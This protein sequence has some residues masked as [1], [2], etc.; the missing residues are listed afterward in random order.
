MR[1]KEDKETLTKKDRFRRAILSPPVE[2]ES[3]EIRSLLVGWAESEIG[4]GGCME[5]RATKRGMTQE[6]LEIIVRRA[7]GSQLQPREI[8]NLTKA[9]GNKI[10][11]TVKNAW[12]LKCK[13]KWVTESRESTCRQKGLRDANETMK[14]MEK[15]GYA[16]RCKKRGECVNL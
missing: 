13:R 5:I 2:S 12:G 10:K 3:L 7:A 9:A 8:V 1:K 6:N 4:N 16:W 15:V 14:K 11:R